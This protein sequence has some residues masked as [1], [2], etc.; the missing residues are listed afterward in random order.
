MV[1]EIYHY[2]ERI[3]E[4][5]LPTIF[6]NNKNDHEKYYLGEPAYIYIQPLI[7]IIWDNNWLIT[8]KTIKGKL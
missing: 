7:H 8:T 3:R 2:V 6:I 1:M 5:L 4:F